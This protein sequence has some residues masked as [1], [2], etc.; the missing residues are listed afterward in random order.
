M[1]SSYLDKFPFLVAIRHFEVSWETGS[2]RLSK[3]IVGLFWR[4]NLTPQWKCVPQTVPQCTWPPS[5]PGLPRNLKV[6]NALGLHREERGRLKFRPDPSLRRKSFW[7]SSS[8]KLGREPKKK[9][10]R[11]DGRGGGGGERRKRLPAK[12]PTILKNCV[13]PR[14][15]LLIGSVLAV[16][17]K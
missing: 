5:R 17:I 8:R 1:L 6:A 16:L 4:T 11:K 12:N 15:Q 13:R 10:K 9:K 3:C 14:T 2:R 7:A